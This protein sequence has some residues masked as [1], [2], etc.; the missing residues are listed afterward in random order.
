MSY[1]VYASDTDPPPHSRSVGEAITHAPPAPAGI[2]HAVH[3]GSDRTMCGLPIDG[4]YL[5]PM[6]VWETFDADEGACPTCTAAIA[7][8]DS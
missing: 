1:Q 5:F 4:L 6:H 2:V 8:K 7:A 3:A